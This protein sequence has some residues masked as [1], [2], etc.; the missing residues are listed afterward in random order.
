MPGL[1]G[2]PYGNS[3]TGF[4]DQTVTINGTTYNGGLSIPGLPNT[5]WLSDLQPTISS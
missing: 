1:G 5:I 4:A 2:S 3:P